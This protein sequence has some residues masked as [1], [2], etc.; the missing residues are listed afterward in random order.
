MELT[1]RQKDILYAIVTEF[2]DSALPVGSGLISDKYEIDASPATIRYEMV[3]LTDEGFISKSHSSSGRIPTLMGLRFYL[4][5]LMDEEDV[6]YLTEIQ[7]TRQ[8]SEVR[9]QRDRLIRGIT[10]L[11][12]DMTKYACVVITEDGIFYSGLY[13]LLDYPEFQDRIVFKNILLAFDDLNTLTNVFERGYTDGRVKVLIGD[14]LEEKI[15]ED[16]SIVFT[17]IN[18]Y[19]GERAILS[20]IGPKRLQFSK[21]IPLIRMTQEIIQKIMVGWES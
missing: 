16:A 17:E 11:L 5:D 18:L 6:N 3:K 9:F 21:V 7:L 10:S 19:R 8:L 1:K 14:E 4:Q 12:A 2:I 20:V 15:L 13:N